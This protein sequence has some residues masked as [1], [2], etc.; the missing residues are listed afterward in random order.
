MRAAQPTVGAELHILYPAHRAGQSRQLIGK[1]ADV[2][3]NKRLQNGG[4][5]EFLVRQELLLLRAAVAEMHLFLLAAHDLCQVYGGRVVAALTFHP[6][7]SPPR[8]ESALF[9]LTNA[10]AEA[11][12]G[13][14]VFLVDRLE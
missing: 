9:K 5:V 12:G 7:S 10:I 13:L 11:R 6:W 2:V 4:Q 1:L 14:V 3:A 8:A